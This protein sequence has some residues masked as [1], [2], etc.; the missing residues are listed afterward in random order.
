MHERILPRKCISTRSEVHLQLPHRLAYG[1][2]LKSKNA[3]SLRWHKHRRGDPEPYVPQQQS[4]LGRTHAHSQRELA[5]PTILI[6]GAGYLF[7]IGVGIRWS[8]F[9]GLVGLDSELW[10]PCVFVR[11]CHG[12]RSQHSAVS[13]RFPRGWVYGRRTSHRF[14]IHARLFFN[15]CQ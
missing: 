2:G 3:S 9:L 11:F 10:D 8:G 1:L 14:C 15:T 12:N 4:L 7:E 13:P 5:R 6:P